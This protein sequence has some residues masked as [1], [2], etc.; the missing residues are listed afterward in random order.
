MDSQE[1]LTHRLILPGDTNHY[2]TLYAGS[3]LRIALEAAYAAAFRLV[4][5]QTKLVLR[6]VLGIE[7]IRPVPAGTVVEIRGLPLHLR[8]AY[9]VVGLLGS[10][11]GS[12]PTPWMDGLMGFVPIDDQ[13]RLTSF[14]EDLSLGEPCADW[15]ELESRMRRLLEL[16]RDS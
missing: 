9:L 7:C 4:G 12:D 5:N 1:T 11:F 14:P 8:R 13:G 16:R 2:G 6:R 15:N 10:P 3:L